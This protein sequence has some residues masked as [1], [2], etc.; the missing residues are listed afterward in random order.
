LQCKTLQEEVGN[1]YK[2]IIVG[3]PGKTCKLLISKD[4]DILIDWLNW[5]HR[6]KRSQTTNLL[7]NNKKKSIFSLEI[8]IFS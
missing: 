1:L 8:D 7:K 2:K 6:L 5:Y 3:A 4:S